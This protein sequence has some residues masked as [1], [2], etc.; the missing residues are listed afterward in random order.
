[1]T[2]QSWKSD[3]AKEVFEGGDPGKGFPQGLIRRLR[4][5]LQ[6]LDAAVVLGDMATPPSNRLHKLA[7]D[8]WS[9]SVN[10]QYRVTFIW[11]DA[12]PEEVWFGD[13]H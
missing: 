4:R 12:G 5:L 3:E 11:G 10:D 7:G 2:I 9:V 13:Y 6:R 8:V 1:M